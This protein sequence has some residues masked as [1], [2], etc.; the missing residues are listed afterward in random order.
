[1]TEACSTGVCAVHSG[2][3]PGAGEE[4]G[5]VSGEAVGLGTAN[6]RMPRGEAGLRATALPG[7]GGASFGSVSQ[8]ITR[9]GGGVGAGR[10]PWRLLF[11]NG[12]TTAFYLSP[13]EGRGGSYLGIKM[14]ESS[15][16]SESSCGWTIINHEG[17]DVEILSSDKGEA[18]G[19]SQPSPD[20]QLDKPFELQAEETE[21]PELPMETLTTSVTLAEKELFSEPA[22]GKMADDSTFVGA[23]SDDS[24]IV[25]LEPPPV[26]DLQ[27][28]QEETEV[29]AQEQTNY[30]ELNLG[31]SSSS[32]YTFAPPETVSTIEESRDESSS[33]ETSGKSSPTLRRRRIRKKTMSSSETEEKPDEDV[34]DGEQQQQQHRFNTTLNKC[35]LLALVIAFSM[36][37][38]HFYGEFE[39]TT[40]IQEQQKIVKKIHEE[41][42]NDVKDDLFQCQKDQAGTEELLEDI[43]EKPDMLLTLTKL[44][45]KMKKENEQLKEKQA[46]LQSQGENLEIRLKQTVDEKLSVESRHQ[47]LAQENQRMKESLEHEEKALSLLQNELRKLREQIRTLE[48]K[49]VDAEIIITENQK[50]KDH[51]EEE[52]QQIQNFLQ[53]KGNLVNEAQ[54]LRKELDK[55]RE[56][57][58]A[59]RKELESLSHLQSSANSEQEGKDTENLQSRLAELEKKL[60]FEQQRSDL[61]ERLYVEAKEEKDDPE[62]KKNSKKPDRKPNQ[63]FYGTRG[64]KHQPK[65]SFMRSVKNGFDAVKNS[66]KEFVRHHKEKIK[67]AKEA[68][69]ENLKKF[70]DSVKSTFRHFQNSAKNLFHK[71]KRREEAQ[72][73][74]PKRQGFWQRH[75]HPCGVN[76]HG[77]HGGKDSCQY[78]PRETA[79]AQYQYS[80]T[81]KHNKMYTKEPINFERS[82]SEHDNFGKH[83]HYRSPKGCSG[84][85]ECAHQESLSLFN[86]VLDPIKVEDFHKLLH[87]YLQQ[88][89]V[90]FQR[91]S[92]LEKFI[93]RFFHNGL[94]IHDQ[95]L[96]SDFV[97]DVEDYLEDIAEHQEDKVDPFDDLDE[98]I[99]RHFFGDNYFNRFGPSQLYDA[100]K[101]KQYGKQ[102]SRNADS[103]RYQRHERKHQHTYHQKERKW[104]K[105][106]RTNGRQMANVEI[107]LGPM[108]FDPKY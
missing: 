12:S 64:K 55:E 16:D 51:L 102:S 42:L 25:T 88:E 22:K 38:G 60:D 62:F 103:S 68:V 70:S 23:T 46:E 54:I 94:F 76:Q 91:W 84:V 56:I 85:F 87:N 26:E 14:S 33:D 6:P 20:Q 24:D 71:N 67:L 83:I 49:G 13:A 9:G 1:M 43:K 52:K 97:N 36:G 72:D 99:Y 79:H 39:G 45:D 75:D 98:Y 101:Y 100:G 7:G 77:V 11:F 82:T 47:I 31:S 107:E 105:P 30:D 48:G 106:G 66:T 61:W 17:S 78:K 29:A 50:L 3:S 74:K 65:E 96:F 63:G 34:V 32:Q 37:F 93:N 40:Q 104:N 92:E 95:M 69:K 8:N 18:E 90:E 5:L 89:V 35:I 108:P 41:E 15:S 80:D 21:H 27:A 53:Q 10:S 73:A 59:L 57:T 44:M 86:K 2:C 4:A 81:R 28:V 58:D 19:I